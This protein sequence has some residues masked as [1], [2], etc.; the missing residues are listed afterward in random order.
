MK[1]N[2]TVLAMLLLTAIGMTVFAQSSSKAD[3]IRSAVQAIV[4]RYPKATLQ[5]IYKSSFQDRF[6]PGHLISNPKAAE[7]YL[8]EE[9]SQPFDGGY[10]LYEPTTYGGNYV[11]V[12]LSVV[13]DSVVP[14]ETMVD[15]FIRSAN[16]INPPTVEQWADEWGEILAVIEDMDLKLDGFECDKEALNEYFKQGHYVVH[17][18]DA[19]VDA[20]DPHYRIILRDI[21]DK[22]I[23]PL[24]DDGYYP[25]GQ[26]KL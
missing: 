15:A 23:K 25:C 2:I 10:P 21:F 6:G 14:F 24:I 26:R 17:H 7:E 3:S 1:R 20:Y 22:D 5:D 11:R 12:S 9:L 13:K 19:F 8:R 16:A 4:N 18:S